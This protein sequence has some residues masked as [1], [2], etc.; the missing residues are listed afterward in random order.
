MRRR[1]HSRALNL[2]FTQQVPGVVTTVHA[3]AASGPATGK[4]V[5]TGG[6][7]GFLDMA[8]ASNPYFTVGAFVQ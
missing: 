7:F 3:D 1:P 6:V 8:D 5:F 4:F 2:D